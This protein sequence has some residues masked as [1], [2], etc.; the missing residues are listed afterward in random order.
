MIILYLV[1]KLKKRQTNYLIVVDKNKRMCHIIDM[2]CPGDSR[3]ALKEEEKL[4]KYQD[5]ALEIKTLWRMH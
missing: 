1:N 4:N 5:L 2:A 3:I